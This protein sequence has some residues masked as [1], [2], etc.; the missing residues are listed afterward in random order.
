[1]EGGSENTKP[2]IFGGRIFWRGNANYKNKD[3]LTG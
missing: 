1:V 3:E 2:K